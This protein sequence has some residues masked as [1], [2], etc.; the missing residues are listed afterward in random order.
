MSEAAATPQSDTKLDLKSLAAEV[1]ARAVKAGASDA[2]AVVSEGDE[3]SVSVRMGEVETLQ[4][5]GSRGLG[6]RVFSG[7]RSASASTSDLTPDGIAQLVSGAMALAKVTEE[8]SFAGLPDRDD[9]GQLESDLHLYYEDVYSLPAAE[10]I[11]RARRAEAAALAV[12]TRITNSQGGGFDAATGRRVLANSRGFLGEYRTSYCG[13]SAVP[14]AIDSNGA[15]Q[16]DSWS[17][18][19]RRLA[20]LESPES[21]G[22]EAARRALR[23]LGARRV[24]TQRVPI[25]FAPEV[26]RSLIGHLFEAASGDSIWRSA[27]FLAGQLG[28]SIAASSITVVDDHTM[29]LP[30]GAG[31]FGTSPFDGDGLPTRRTVV[32][33]NGTLQTYLLNTYTARKL[34]MRS[35]G[36]ATRGLA[37]S[38]GIGSGNLYLLPGTQT[39]E[40]ILAEIPTGFYVTSLMGFGANLVTGDYSRGASGL[41]IENGELTYAVEE[42]TIAGNLREMLRNITAIG[43]DLVFRSSVASPTL[44]VDGMTVAGA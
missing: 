35:T 2:E 24:P 28:E 4:E 5:S 23:R 17:S 9:F 11:D 15:M 32:V 33:E 20:D 39:P 13:I 37:G 26:A 8:D 3:F 40:A 36:N 6:L 43:N 27:S 18:S 42:V 14:L 12:D 7:Q 44:R 22:Q 29:L 25:V 30:N 19:A 10:R 38:P 1:I 41:W 34:G 21:I 31:G 16:R